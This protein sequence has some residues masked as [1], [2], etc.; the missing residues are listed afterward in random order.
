MIVKTDAVVLRSIPFRDTSKIVT[1]Y[2]RRYGRVSVVAK[3]AREIKS[4][5]GAALEPMS[6]I[7]VVLFRRETRDL[8]TLTQAD[9][10]RPW[11]NLVNDLDKLSAGLRVIELVAQAM[12][13]EDENPA[14]F[15]LIVQTLD[16]LNSAPPEAA[17]TLLL[18][19]QLRLAG[20]LGYQPTFDSCTLC[21]DPVLP[22]DE[23]TG[24]REPVGGYRTAAGPVVPFLI[25]RGGAACPTCALT[26]PAGYSVSP[27]AIRLVDTLL[28][29]RMDA[30]LGLP[31][32]PHLKIQVGE[33]LDA[34]LMQHVEGVKTSRTARVFGQMETDTAGR[35][36]I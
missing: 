29:A 25:G 15:N 33:M 34:Y 24:V 11:L 1:L 5:F 12:H 13:D 6:H 18:F 26:H 4:R 14:A 23:P 22:D 8:Q 17:S 31:I 2:T 30:A 32:P 7:Q 36:L 16:R 28:S 9:L 35:P 27:E 20:V 19:F 10:V 3:G 21:G